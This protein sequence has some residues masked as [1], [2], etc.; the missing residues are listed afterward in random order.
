MGFGSWLKKVG[1]AVDPT[2]NPANLFLPVAV[3][4]AVTAGAGGNSG[5]A[6]GTGSGGAFG[7]G[8]PN[9][10][11]RGLPAPSAGGAGESSVPKYGQQLTPEPQ[12]AYKPQFSMPPA[13]QNAYY[14]Q[15]GAVGAPPGGAPPG[16]SGMLPP[17]AMQA[18]GSVQ[19]GQMLARQQ[20]QRGPMA[21]Q[22]MLA[23][24]L[25]GRAGGR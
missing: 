19:Q 23:S 9:T 25:R 22:Q 8:Q 1:R 21:A 14:A 6:S 15:H 13:A 16:P 17:P 24:A 18:Q 20:M 2:S 3:T 7:F 11:F 10:P 5:G 4:N 12:G